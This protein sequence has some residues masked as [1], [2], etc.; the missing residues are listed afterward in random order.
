MGRPDF[1]QP[2]T[3][4]VPHHL[5]DDDN[6]VEGILLNKSLCDSLGC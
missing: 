2:T 3:P 5:Q 1:R 6:A 4:P